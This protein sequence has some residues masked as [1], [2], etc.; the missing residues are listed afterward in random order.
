VP[1]N[2]DLADTWRQVAGRVGSGVWELTEKGIKLAEKE[3][4]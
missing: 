2:L 4:G 1:A 3:V